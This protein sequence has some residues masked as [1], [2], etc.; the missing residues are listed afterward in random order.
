[1]YGLKI[2]F[3]KWHCS[4]IRFLNYGYISFD[5]SF[6]LY[7]LEHYG[8]SSSAIELLRSYLSDRT[9]YVEFKSTRSDLGKIEIGVPQGSIL[10]P[11]LFLIFINDIHLST[12]LLSTILYADD[13]TFSLCLDL[14]EGTP[15]QK[16]VKINFELGQ[17]STWLT[18]NRL[19]L[20]VSKTKFMIFNK[21]HSNTPIKLFISNTELE[22]VTNFSFLGLT[23][24]ESL[25][26]TPHL[27]K[28][29]RKLSRTLG[30]MNNLKHFLPR[31][32]MRTIYF[33]IFHS[34]LNY[35]ILTWGSQWSQLFVMQKKAQRIIH[36]S[37]YLGHTEDLSSKNREFF[38]LTTYFNKFS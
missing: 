33:S 29:S 9:Q 20:N 4:F 17:I 38:V 19:C 31:S 7:K 16:S 37:H 15:N 36:N 27:T 32:I 14:L 8:L 12:N 18:A 22:Q 34:H 6:L 26:W 2:G 10:G 30:I 21:K 28:V 3:P 23:V 5:H 35:Q 11:L 25:D 1:M 24:N 13:S